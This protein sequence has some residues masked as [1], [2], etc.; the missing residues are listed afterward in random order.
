MKNYKIINNSS[1]MESLNIWH[2]S[3]PK[4]KETIKKKIYFNK[5][6]DS[7]E[8]KKKNENTNLEN[9]IEHNINKY[10]SS[11]DE[12]ITKKRLKLA[13]QYIQKI[14]TEV[15][16][17]DFDAKNIDKD[18]ISQRLNENI[19]FIIYINRS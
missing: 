9:N 15:G 1:F 8:N 5:D 2:K 17:Y 3:L 14:Q 11:D 10:L 18:L 13:K 4:K 12:S 6:Y 16:D 7:N 19:V